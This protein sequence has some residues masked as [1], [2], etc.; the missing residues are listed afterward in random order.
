MKRQLELRREETQ[1]LHTKCDALES[2]LAELQAAVQY[3][4]VKGEA[5]PARS[6][7]SMQV[8]E[9][10]HDEASNTTLED[11]LRWAEEIK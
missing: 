1:A 7:S 8:T 10:A 3:Q 11:V 6:S 5:E 2:K 4:N 9:G